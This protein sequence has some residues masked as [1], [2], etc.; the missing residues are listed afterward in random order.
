MAN[1][2]VPPE[3][4]RALLTRKQMAALLN[5]STA[6]LDRWAARDPHFPVI[7]GPRGEVFRFSRRQVLDYIGQGNQP[8]PP[9]KRLRR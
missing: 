6:T 7:R 3:D 5:I 2:V 1:D 4:Q 9:A 8:P